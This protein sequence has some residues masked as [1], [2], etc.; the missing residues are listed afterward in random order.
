METHFYEVLTGVGFVVA[1]LVFVTLFL[2]SAPYG[3]HT[4]R[5]WGP[6]VNETPGWVLMELPAVITIAVC[7]VW[8]HGLAWSPVWI[9]LILWEIHYVHR[10]FIFPFRLRRPGRKTPILIVL[11]AILFNVFNGYMNGRYLGLHAGEYTLDWFTDPRFVAGAGLFFSGMAINLHADQVLFKL[12]QNGGAE[13]GIPQG[14]LYR[15]ISCP[16]YFGE[17]L[18]WMGWALATW[19]LPGLLFAVWTAANLVPRAI[20]HHRWY[21]ERFAEYPAER[22]AIVPFV[23]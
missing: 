23:W 19:C 15:W 6:T 20:T 10:T 2:V 3:R 21:R 17:L 11:F 5:G 12:R 14:G 7:F 4:R 22:K 9:F 1:A 13:Y 18:E 16:N 8:G